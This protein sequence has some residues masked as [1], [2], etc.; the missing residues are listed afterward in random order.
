MAHYGRGVTRSAANDRFFTVDDAVLDAAFDWSRRR[1]IEG[2]DPSTSA[3]PVEELEQALA[4]SICEDGIGGAET[5]R[6]FTE[7]IVTATRAQGAPMNLAYVPGAPTPASL[8]CDLMLGTAEIFAGLWESGA[9]A[10]HAENQALRWLS[11]LAGFPAEAGGTFVQGGTVGNLSALVSARAKARH[12][13]RAPERWAIAATAAAHSSVAAAARSLDCDVI[14]VTGDERGRLTGPALRSAIEAADHPGLFA[15]VATAGTTNAGIIDDL[16][17]VA[18]VCHDLDLWLHVDGAYGLAGLAAP[19]LRP[20]YAGIEQA[21]S[22]IVDPHKWLFAPYDCCALVYRDPAWGAAAHAQHASYLEHL[23]RT[24]WNPA[25]YAIQLTRR[26]RGLPFW[27]SLATHGTAAYGEAVERGVAA[28]HTIARHI[29]ASDYLDLLIEPELSVVL[30]ERRGWSA[31]QM[32][33]WSEHHR[34]EGTMLCVPTRWAG[35]PVFRLC[36]INPDTHADNVI[37]ILA[38]MAGEP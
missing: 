7:S 6:R 21:D 33:A 13:G 11:D 32:L 29:E 34:V 8:V 3:Q 36:V 14:D 9:G 15:V 37:E 35:R 24:E 5:L 20:H 28:A 16:T 10:I 17:G 27:F 38:T 26:A 4:G 18:G 25:D 1:I 22:F 2:E 31:D 12:G 30:F 19:S 23:D